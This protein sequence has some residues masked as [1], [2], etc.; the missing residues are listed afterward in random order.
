MLQLFEYSQIR[1]FRSAK[2]ERKVYLLLSCR[3]YIRCGCAHRRFKRIDAGVLTG[4]VIMGNIEDFTCESSIEI[5]GVPNIETSVVNDIA[6][7]MACVFIKNKNTGRGDYENLL[8]DFYKVRDVLD[9]DEIPPYP[10]GL[11]KQLQTAIIEGD[12]KLSKEL[13]NKLLGHIFFGSNGDFRTI[14]TRVTELIV[15]L[16]RSAIDGGADMEQVFLLNKNY[17][18]EIKAFDSL[19]KLSIWLSG[20]INRFISY[21]FEFNDV[22]HTDVIFKVINY[23]K[24]NYK[25]KLT[26]DD[27]SSYVYL[28]K[29]YLS[30]IFKDEMKCTITNYI[31]SVRV[32]KSKQLLADSSLSL[33]DIAYFVGFEDQSYY[34]KCLKNNQSFSGKIQK[35]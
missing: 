14:K 10:L 2:M 12:S 32:E 28:S 15:L 8:N 34:T 23:I 1:L 19:D 3:F 35:Y 16:S 13:L 21:V 25:E 26:L 17:I 31:N 5:R 11:E 33:A 24:Q 18:D 22:K 20:V 27:I 9:E 30:K 4:P 29:S 6:E 7:I